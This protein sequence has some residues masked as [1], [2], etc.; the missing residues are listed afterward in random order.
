MKLRRFDGEWEIILEDGDEG[1]FKV[2][3][4]ILEIIDY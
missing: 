3:G 4:E 1:K 2:D